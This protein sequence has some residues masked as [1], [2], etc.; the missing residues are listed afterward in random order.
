MRLITLAVAIILLSSAA[1]YYDLEVRWVKIDKN[2]VVEGEIVNIRARIDNNGESHPFNVYFYLD[3]MLIKKIH[4]ESI[5]KYRLPS[6]K[7][8]TK[9]HAGNHTI[10]VK[11]DDDYDNSN[12][13]GL[14]RITIIK[15][16]PRKDAIIK[17]FYPYTNAGVNCEYVLVSTCNRTCSGLYI[18]TQPWKRMDKQNK[19]YLP[20]FKGEIYITRNGSAFI[21]QMG[22]EA[23]YEY[24]NVSSTPDIERKGAIYMPNNGGAIA[25]KDRFNNT[26][27]CVVYGNFSFSDEWYGK[28]IPV[29]EG[30]IL[31][32][33]C[34]DTNTFHEWKGR[35]AGASHFPP[36][37]LTVKNAT[38]FCS[39]DCSYDVVSNA[40]EGKNISINIYM[41]TNP[42]LYRILEKQNATVRMLLDGNVIGG[43]PVEE[44]YILWKL[45]SNKKADVKYIFGNEKYHI[46]KRY[47]FDHAKYA[48]IDDKCIIESANWV[49]NGIPENP[50]YG[51]REW[52]VLIENESLAR[53]LWKIFKYDFNQKFM[54]IIPFNISH[55]F[56][57]KPK[58]FSLFFNKINGDYKPVFHPEK[59]EEKFN[60]TVILSPDN[61]EEE[62]LKLIRNARKEILIEQAYIQREWHDGINPFL[63]ALIEKAKEGV[64]VKVLMNYNE[65]YYSTNRMNEETMKY[66]LSNGIEAKLAKINIH[67]KGMIIDDEIT[68]IS[69]INW[70]ENSV[71]NNREMGIII[72]DKNASMYF[73]HVFDYDWK[74]MKKSEYTD[75]QIYAIAGIFIIT[76]FIIYL[77]RR[78]ND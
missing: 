23:D 31:Y 41:F 40:I 36:F 50:T 17:E 28:P 62:I 66:L 37:S 11:V 1:P 20:A 42:F 15:V 63:K 45:K 30:F 69:S 54:D 46:Y 6:V 14:C 25:I 3:G 51:N 59:E 12:N 8:D 33:N 67:N 7:F 34:N 13:E 55:P 24:Y 48:I 47:A 57:G 49:R 70:G 76:A 35:R 10:Y 39:P 21:K 61:A 38:F 29:K 27:D 60:V 53:V 16:I 75:M 78:K 43:I 74:Y 77:G 56:M 44:R 58:N 22:F 32:R 5:N 52:G 4:Y 2:V 26:I 68:L 71:R 73:H 18:T 65:K 64:K 9:G 19:I 72:Y